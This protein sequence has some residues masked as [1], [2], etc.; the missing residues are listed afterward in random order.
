MK[1]KPL[2]VEIF[3]LVGW[4]LKRS[5]KDPR[6]KPLWTPP[7][8]WSPQEL[9]LIHENFQLTLDWLVPIM[10]NLKWNWGV[11]HGAPIGGGPHGGEQHF[12][13]YWIKGDVSIF[14]AIIND[15]VALAACEAALPI[16]MELEKE[17]E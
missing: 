13:F 1:K 3:E 7:D 15:N 9:P 17:K 14:G 11:E 12:D 2:N 6:W 8:I 5:G 4:E 10:R 16:L